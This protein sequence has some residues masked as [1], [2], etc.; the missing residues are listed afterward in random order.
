MASSSH[1]AGAD[2][3]KLISK[4]FTACETGDVEAIEGVL[5]VHKDAARQFVNRQNETALQVAVM[6]GR[7]AIMRLLIEHGAEVDKPQRHTGRTAL[8]FAAQGTNLPA[9]G[10]L[11]RANADLLLTDMYSHTPFYYVVERGPTEMAKMFLRYGADANMEMEPGVPVLYYT[12]RAGRTELARMLLLY[13]AKPDVGYGSDTPLMAAV[14]GQHYDTVEVLLDGGAQVNREN[15]ALETALDVAVN[16]N[17]VRMVRLLRGRAAVMGI[18]VTLS[19]LNDQ[20]DGVEVVVH[21]RQRRRAP[22]P[23]A[24]LGFLAGD[25]RPHHKVDGFRPELGDNSDGEGVDKPA[26]LDGGDVSNISVESPSSERCFSEDLNPRVKNPPKPETAK[27]LNAKVAFKGPPIGRRGR[28]DTG[29]PKQAAGA[30]FYPPTSFDDDQRACC[31]SV[32]ISIMDFYVRGD[33]E[34]R[35]PVDGSV[36]EVLYGKGPQTMRQEARKEA[37]LNA[38]PDFTWYHIPSNNRTWAEHL[39]TKLRAESGQDCQDGREGRML[40]RMRQDMREW[41]RLAEPQSGKDGS[42]PLFMAAGCQGL[43]RANS[44]DGGAGSGAGDGD[45]RA[46]ITTLI[47]R[48]QLTLSIRARLTT[49]RCRTWTTRNTRRFSRCGPPLTNA[50]DVGDC[51][52][53]TTGLLIR[54]GMILGLYP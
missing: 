23:S 26:G 35:L 49:C 13:D 11:F 4:L 50:P 42:G 47:V 52:L 18:E 2:R 34:L 17:D 31:E 1:D 48:Y 53:P 22:A 29:L 27:A 10:L 8:H 44:D 43:K 51:N 5:K 39:I 28:R 16:Q 7:V 32:Q 12:A 33:E 19:R 40:R 37:G 21:E 6:Y 9:V 45:D 41:M 46:K 25:R 54:N 36:F 3:A 20:H 24:L 38:K 30:L 15:H 14:R